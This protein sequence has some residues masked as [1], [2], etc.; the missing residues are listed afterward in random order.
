M[1]FSGDDVS[2]II[3]LSATASDHLV[4]DFARL[5]RSWFESDHVAMNEACNEVS[6]RFSL[7]TIERQLFQCLDA[8]STLLSPITWVRRRVES[9]SDNELTP[10]IRSRSEHLLAVASR[11]QPIEIE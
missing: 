5:F 4:T 10:E 3:D 1:L 8:C 7:T 6:Q 2:G 11:F 9:L